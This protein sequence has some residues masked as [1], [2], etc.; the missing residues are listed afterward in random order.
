MQCPDARDPLVSVVV[1]CYNRADMVCT[2]LD[3]V[4]NQTYRP[5]ELIVVDDGSKDN[6]M[7][8]IEDWRARHPDGNGFSS[9]A[10]TFPNGKLCVARNRGLALAHGDYIQYVDDDDWLYP[11]AIA[12]KMAYASTHP[13]LDLIVNQLDYV[14]N[15]KK[16]N[17]TR[18]ALPQNGENLIAWLLD[19]ECLIS[20]V[21]MFKTDT[22][23]KIGAWKEGL[24]FADDMEITMRLA[25]L[26]GRFGM[27]DERLSGYRVHAQV[28][29]C[30]TIRDRLS[31]DFIS[32]LYSDLYS[33]ALKQNIMTNDVR[34]SFARHLLADAAD[35]IRI[36]RYDAARLCEET[37]GK[38]APELNIGERRTIPLAW[39]LSFW[40][41]RF[42]HF[43]KQKIKRFRKRIRL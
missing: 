28:R 23:R 15:G 8:V 33:L 14:R 20:P 11:E 13:E 3:S 30:T 19:H 43:I 6:S 39:R 26:G 27:V 37:A 1:T 4:W 7:E 16:I 5:L 35:M 17:H 25:I 32:T 21:L 31:D 36:G 34:L 38:I 12:R 22:L 18:I 24:I 41:H 40:R 10:K 2:A 29:Q 9:V 42:F